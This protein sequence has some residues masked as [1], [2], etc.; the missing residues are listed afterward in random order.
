MTDARRRRTLAAIERDELPPDLVERLRRGGPA[1]SA[2]SVPDSTALRQLRAEPLALVSGASV[3]RRLH[4]PMP[5]PAPRR[6]PA[7]G[8]VRELAV[9]S[10]ALNT[11]R[12]RAIRR[13][14]EEAK[15][16]GA[17]AVVGIRL[18]R[19]ERVERRDDFLD[20][21]EVVA[22]GTAVHLPGAIGLALTTLAGSEL[23]TLARTGWRPLDLVASSTVCYVVSGRATVDR[24][25]LT[26]AQGGTNS[27]YGDY[28][29]GV[30]A[31]RSRAIGR[32]ESAARRAGAAGIVG[33][34]W[35]Q[36]IK[37]VAREGFGTRDLEVTLHVVGTSIAGSDI[38]TRVGAAVALA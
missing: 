10:D 5:S 8:L 12:A 15:L 27:E 33:L 16:A 17:N 32:V 4:Q 21:V 36:E 20:L 1:T 38:P 2:L 28:T 19:S 26:W 7:D 6:M 24:F 11:A 14:R 23:A 31:A 18:R 30:Y 25:G 34:T 3:V 13:L 29:R 37:P 35:E 9:I 22:T